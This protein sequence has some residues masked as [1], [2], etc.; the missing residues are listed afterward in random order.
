MSLSTSNYTVGTSAAQVTPSGAINSYMLIVQNNHASNIVY[1]GAA[2]TVTSSAYGVALAAGASISLDDLRP[3]DQVWV[4]A[5][6]GSTPV[7]TFAIIR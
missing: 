4:I 1:V 3:V 5:S 6:A 2:S 7:S